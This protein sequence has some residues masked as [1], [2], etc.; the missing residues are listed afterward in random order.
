MDVAALCRDLVGIRSENPPGDTRDIAEY[1][2]TF[3][4]ESGIENVV[5]S[6][7]GKR[8]NLIAPGQNPNLLLVG[9]LDV[10]PAIPTGWRHPPF[11]GVEEGGYIW[12]RGSSDMKG[13]CA[14]LLTALRRVAD[15]GDAPSCQ[16]VFV[17]DEETGGCHGM[18]YLL[19]KG[20][21]RPCDTLIAEPTPRLSPCIGQKGLARLSLSFSGEPGHS[22]L[23]PEVGRSAIMEAHA[24]ISF[25][26]ELHRREYPVSGEM[27]EIIA[28]SSEV[29]E[30][31]FGTQGLDRVLHRVMFNPGVISGG[32]K[33]NIVAERC[34]LDLDLRIPWGC[35][36]GEIVSE[37]ASHA[38][39]ADLKVNSVS[40]PS[41]TPP[42]ATIATR[43]SAGIR[44][45]YGE[46][47]VPIFQ[48]A[49][50][51]ARHLRKAG[52]PTVEY[53]PG[54]IK[55]IHGIN[56]RVSIDSLRCA[57]EIYHGI[58]LSYR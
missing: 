20:V 46:E 53:G 41:F 32:E 16:V 8:C 9:H 51:D 4:L 19:A 33:A 12:G 28:Q 15:E 13:G 43:V 31:I 54:E 56:E 44:R 6:R 57:E 42:F 40:E 49:A 47:V 34:D 2:H 38:P 58:I 55:T 11:E 26:Q 29:L 5:V 36:T 52:F 14:S 22:S 30:G 21:L 39:A 18:E 3:M 27:E 17:C 23:Y 24:L 1:I 37:I 25:L 45:V 48:W 10:V 35:T 7:D 50:S